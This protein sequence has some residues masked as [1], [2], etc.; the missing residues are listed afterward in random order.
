MV[1][2]GL[3]AV[4]VPQ[5]EK[6]DEDGKQ[7]QAPARPGQDQGRQQEQQQDREPAII[8]RIRNGRQ[9]GRDRAEGKAARGNPQRS[10]KQQANHQ[11]NNDHLLQP[12]NPTPAPGNFGPAFRS[13]RHPHSAAARG[14]WTASRGGI[15][16]PVANR[17]A[18][19]REL[20]SWFRTRPSMQNGEE[21]WDKFPTCPTL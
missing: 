20:R 12:E 15:I 5:P 7:D 13:P 19:E 4:L 14:I 8:Q 16:S 6:A 3:P 17:C 10:R 1:E 18:R 9:P 21:L 11:G 2:P